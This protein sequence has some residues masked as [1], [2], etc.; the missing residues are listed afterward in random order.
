MDLKRI[1]LFVDSFQQEFPGYECE[2]RPS[3]DKSLD[4]TLFFVTNASSYI[5]SFFLK[6][7]L[8]NDLEPIYIIW[9][10]KRVCLIEKLSKEKQPVVGPIGIIR[11][12]S[13]EHTPSML[14][15]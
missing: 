13:P 8:L 3:A 5:G 14:Q 11:F 12:E 1:L 9:I 2:N 15:G 10:L 6:N 7:E 4:A